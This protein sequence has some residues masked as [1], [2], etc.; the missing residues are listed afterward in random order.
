MSW[1][2]LDTRIQTIAHRELTPKQLD[3]FK[4]HLAGCGHKRV[5]LMLNIGTPTARS[6]LD[7][8]N[9]RLAKHGVRLVSD[10]HYTIEEA[11]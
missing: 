5:A 8:A 4:L 10:R 3:V 9:Q 2:L 7:A 6:H 1:S 11:A